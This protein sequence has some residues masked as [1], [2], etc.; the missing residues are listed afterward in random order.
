MK[1]LPRSLFAVHSIQM[2]LDRIA[3][4]KPFVAEKIKLVAADFVRLSND[5]PRLL[6]KS[7]TQQ[8]E[9]G[10]DGP[11]REEKLGRPYI[12]ATSEALRKIKSEAR[13]SSIGTLGQFLAAAL[14][15]FVAIHVP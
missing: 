2:P 14:Q 11:G 3:V 13:E 4:F 12:C 15:E 8:V 10:L 5:L 6:R 9:N 1:S 7:L